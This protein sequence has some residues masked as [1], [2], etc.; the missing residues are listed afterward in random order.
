MEESREY[1][2]GRCET[3]Q[4]SIIEAG[5]ALLEETRERWP[6]LKTIVRVEATGVTDCKESKETRYCISDRDGC[7]A[8]YYNAL[9]GGHRSI[10]NHLHW[11]LDVT[12]GKDQSRARRGYAPENLSTIRKPALQTIKEHND[13][14]S[15]KKGGQGGI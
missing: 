12:F 14:L 15:L 9:V 1:D 4:C 10:E 7:D 6:H 2:R 8:A 11:H 5:T 13:K 3:R